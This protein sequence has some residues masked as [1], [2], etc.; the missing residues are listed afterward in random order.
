VSRPRRL[1]VAATVAVAG[2][3][4]LA[5]C[6]GN[7]SGSGAE[8]K[9]DKTKLVVYSG[10]QKTLVEPLFEAFEKRSGVKVSARYA[11]SAELAQ[12]LIEEG[13][14]SEVDVFFSQDA[15]ALGALS[16]QGRLA[17]LPQTTLD[18]VE[19]RFRSQSG[20]WVGV[21]G[22]ARVLVYDPAKVAAAEL[23]RAIDDVTSDRWK[24]KVGFAPTNASFQAFVTGLR[25]VKGDDAA[26]RWL[27]EFKANA[28]KAYDNNLAILDA[29]E[30]GELELGLINH[31]Y[32]YEK[33]H[34]VGED[35][36]KSKLH[37]FGNGDPG[38]LVNVAG[39]GVLKS[40]D[41]A[42]EAQQFVDFL[43][44]PEAQTYFRD[45]TFEY[46]LTDDVDAAGD[47][48]E[49]DQLDAPDVDLSELS[50]LEQT[51]ALLDEVGLT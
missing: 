4:L 49:L 20:T 2:A 38:G 17:A 13:D 7:A 1:V 46:P 25:V 35:A 40:T 34:E 50:T 24:G 43:L 21:S 32:W 42:A 5:G 16:K 44:S 28:P 41:R 11:G 26:K 45:T 29:V 6:S 31:Y 30:R 8:P 14:R 18:R 47:L 51:L 3:L 23:P 39:A 19:S 48:P 15:G 37:F 12:Q 22:R 9:V 27:E 33:A 36:M 10:R